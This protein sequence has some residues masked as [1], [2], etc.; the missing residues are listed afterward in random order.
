MQG[1]RYYLL[2]GFVLVSDQVTKLAVSRTLPVGESR[3]VLGRYL[4]LT[5]TW[6]TGGAFSLLQARN[7]VFVLVA[8][9][10]I[11]ALIYFL[12][13]YN[14][15]DFYVTIAISLALGGA[16]GNLTDRLIY[17]HVIDFLDVHI[18][19]IFNVADSAITCGI[20]L[21]AWRFLRPGTAAAPERLL[22][23]VMVWACM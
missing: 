13:R 12:N 3:P 9:I 6:N 23:R 1:A 18:W 5:H 16:L 17:G 20:L 10:T 7:M 2:S 8:A 11:A 19:P 22:P 21:L 14:S 15:R 4:A